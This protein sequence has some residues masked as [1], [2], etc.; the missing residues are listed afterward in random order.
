MCRTVIGHTATTSKF[1]TCK[2]ASVKNK[3]HS[4]YWFNLWPHCLLSYFGIAQFCVTVN[5]YTFSPKLSHSIPWSFAPESPCYLF[6]PP[7]C[8]ILS[9]PF[10]FPVLFPV[11]FL[12]CHAA[13]YLLLSA[14]SPLLLILPV[15]MTPSSRMMLAWSNCPRML[16]SLRKERRCLSEQPAR[17]VFMATGSSLLLG[18]FRQPRHTSPK[19]PVVGDKW[20]SWHLLI[21]QHPEGVQKYEGKVLY[22]RP[23]MYGTIFESRLKESKK[24]CRERGLAW[25]LG[26]AGAESGGE[27]VGR[28]R[29]DPK[30]TD[31]IEG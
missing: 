26:K 12:S 23:M 10:Y 21:N 18:S 28:E 20:G 6:P 11:A 24:E 1:Q 25:G 9:S 15:V 30:W 16:A 17:N 19:S 31:T 7:L 3:A 27:T 22:S 2:K 14:S 8:F 5:Q 13:F 29:D 4:C